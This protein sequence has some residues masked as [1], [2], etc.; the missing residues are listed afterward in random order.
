MKLYDKIRPWLAQRYDVATVEKFVE[1]QAGKPLPPGSF[2]LRQIPEA[3][4]A[5]VALD[6]RERAVLTSV[7][8]KIHIVPF[9]RGFSTT[10]LIAK[11][12]RAA[13]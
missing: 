3:E 5:I 11:I 6:P 13:I 10:G 7:G 4:G 2:A 8:S 9:V 12:K 1:H